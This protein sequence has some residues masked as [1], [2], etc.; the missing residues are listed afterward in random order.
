MKTDKHPR[1]VKDMFNFI[2]TQTV[3]KLVGFTNKL[4]HHKNT[5]TES[6]L[7][8]QLIVWINFHFVTA[9]LQP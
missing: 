7:K 4:K 8:T 2:K 9:L 3:V 5:T 1:R 6:Q